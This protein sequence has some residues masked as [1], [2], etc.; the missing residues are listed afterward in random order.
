M[1]LTWWLWALGVIC[2]HS[3][4]APGSLSLPKSPSPA[5]IDTGIALSS[6]KDQPEKHPLGERGIEGKKT[7]SREQLN[8]PE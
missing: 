5:F 3:G 1:S 6:G 7:L 2:E 4:T 8:V